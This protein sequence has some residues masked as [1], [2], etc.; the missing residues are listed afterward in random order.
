MVNPNNAKNVTPA[1]SRWEVGAALPDE[2]N[3]ALEPYP[4]YLRHIF[5]NRGI[6]DAAAADSF[7]SARAPGVTDPFLLTG[8]AAAVKRLEQAVQSGEKVAVYGDYDVDGVTA[9]VLMV[10]VLRAAGG[11]VQVKIPNRFE[12]GYGLNN[13]AIQKLAEEGVRLVV[14]VDCGARSPREADLARSLGVDMIISDHHQPGAELPDV[15]ALIN[16]RQPGDAYPD[17]DLAGVGL[18]YKLAEGFFQQHAGAGAAAE[19]WLD[20]VALGTVADMAP[21]TGENRALVTRGLQQIRA[22]TRQGIS[23]LAGAASLD[24]THTTARDIGFV[25]APR[26]N[27]AGRLESAQ[28][29]FDLLAT[30]DPQIAGRLAQDLGNQNYERQRITKEIQQQAAEI[31]LRDNPQAMLLF[32]AHPRFNEGV[33]GLAAARLVDNFY[34][35]AIVA[36]I[37]ADTTRGSCRSI[38]EFHITEALDQCTELLVRH[39]GHRAAAGFTVRNENLETLIARLQAIALAQLGALDLRPVLKAD[40]EFPLERLGEDSTETLFSYLAKLQP[41]GMGNLEPVF[42]AR[43]LV[44]KK[45]RTVGKDGSHLQLTVMDAY[46]A[47]HDAIAFRQSQ[48]ALY[49]PG[50]IDLIYSLEKDEYYGTPRV[51]LNVKGIRPTQPA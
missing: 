6:L 3:K 29:A 48:W 44:V 45:T 49:M 11:D 38:P 51:K 31:A 20:L 5:F 14:T 33:I 50:H 34:R 13:E 26:L 2:V 28:A 32:A 40:C 4:E 9:A 46:G 35:P 41:N 17:K 42:M 22:Q 1:P 37:G 10:E 19:Q 21:L 43:N 25:L 24:I 12:E 39:G 27:A 7:L 15:V 16:P 36:T 8:M 18:A 30:R 23:S 47:L